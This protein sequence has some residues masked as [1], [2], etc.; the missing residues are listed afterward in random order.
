MTEREREK[1]ESLIFDLRKK[2]DLFLQAGDSD[3]FNRIQST[4]ATLQTIYGVVKGMKRGKNE[5][6]A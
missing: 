5:R 6:T 2:G 4:I 3:S 1:A